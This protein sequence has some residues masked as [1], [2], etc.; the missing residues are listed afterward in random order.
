M[1]A[2][3]I[4]RPLDPMG[5]VVLP[6]ELR[7]TLSIDKGDPLEIFVDGQEIILKKYEPAC[8]YCGEAKDIKSVEGKNICQ[9]CIEKIKKHNLRSLNRLHFTAQFQFV[10]IFTTLEIIHLFD[11]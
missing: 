7:R 8:I 4:V 9:E 6:K 5:R 1:K 11:F 3:G 2:M 10:Y